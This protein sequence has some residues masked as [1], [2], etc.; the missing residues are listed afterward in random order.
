MISLNP[1]ERPNAAQTLLLLRNMQRKQ[2]HTNASIECLVFKEF[3][4]LPDSLKLA[5]M[6][7]LN[8][9]DIYNVLQLN[10]AYSELIDNVWF[11]HFCKHT[12]QG[13]KVMELLHESSP[14]L[15]A[16]TVTCKQHIANYFR[17]KR[18]QSKR[19]LR[20]VGKSTITELNP[21]HLEDAGM[22]ICQISTT[23]A[24]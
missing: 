6:C 23:C 3:Q 22:V 18:P 5:I 14:T 4:L 9:N 21:D 12:E 20:L 16:T 8:L 11:H 1:A 7:Y 2:Q 17:F 15:T 24:I 10:K 19:A 13:K